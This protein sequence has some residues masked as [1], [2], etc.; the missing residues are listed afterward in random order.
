MYKN[1]WHITC[2]YFKYILSI[3]F[4]NQP[5]ISLLAAQNSPI[6][7]GTIAAWYLNKINLLC[8]LPIFFFSSFTLLL[9]V[10]LWSAG[11]LKEMICYYYDFLHWSTRL[12]QKKGGEE[13]QQPSGLQWQTVPAGWGRWLFSLLNTG[14][15]TSGLLCQLWAPWCK[16][17]VD[18]LQWVRQRPM[19]MIEDMECLTY[20]EKLRQPRKNKVLSSFCKCW[21]ECEQS[22]MQ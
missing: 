22:G 12:L 8:V 10:M 5:C 21:N 14:E 4:E 6:C 3:F 13:S 9:N 17:G 18:K 1:D 7:F 2:G 16:K 20:K 19:R 11:F 15:A